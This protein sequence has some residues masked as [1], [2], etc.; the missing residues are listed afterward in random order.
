MALATY[1]DLQ[2]S[3]LLWSHRPD[4]A[5]NVP[6]FVALAETRM[7]R[8]LKILQLETTYPFS[9]VVGQATYPLPAN[10]V[11]LTRIYWTDTDG[12]QWPMYEFD[13]SLQDVYSSNFPR[14]YAA[15]AGLITVYPTPSVVKPITMVFREKLPALATVSTN[16]VLT[17]AP[18]VYL[19]GTLVELADYCKSDDLQK[20]EGRYQQ[21]VK[22]VNK[23]DNFK[24][25]ALLA[26]DSA[27]RDRRFNIYT[28][29]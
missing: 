17:N 15:E 26:T 12:Q 3:V 21:A 29:Y 24:G 20:W 22:T 2:A 23:A 8:D 18:N 6:D 9:T 27:L 1:A 10:A 7:G 25:K 16:Y 4:L 28:G 19:F 14:W 13:A 5:A 11:S